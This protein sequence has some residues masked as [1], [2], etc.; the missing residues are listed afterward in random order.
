MS[1]NRI[2]VT[3]LGLVTSLGLDL[4]TCWQNLKD[5]K[6]GARTIT[7]FDTAKNYTK[8]ACLL[9]DDF[10]TALRK[11][12]KRR[13]VRQTTATGQVAFM[14]AKQ[15]VEQYNLDF[16]KMDRSRIGVIMGTG[17][18][19]DL[20]SDLEAEANNQYVI[21]KNM[22]NAVAARIAMEFQLEG[23]AMVVATACAS[24]ADALG[25]AQ[26]LIRAGVID[27]AV[28]GGADA[29]VN[30]FTIQ[31]FNAVMALSERNDDPA[32]A[33]RPFDKNRDGFVFGEGAGLVFL[34][35]E[36][37]AKARGANIICEHLG[38]AST[39]EAADIMRPKEGGAGM[40]ITMEKALQDAGIAP[41][42]VD[43]ISAHGT[44][45]PQND[46]SETM[47]I[48]DV[49]G[50]HAHKLAV[51]SQKSMLG[52]AVGGSGGIEFVVTSKIIEEGFITPTINYETPDEGMDLDYVPNEGRESDV[53]VALSNSFA[54]GGH[55]CTHIL[56]KYQG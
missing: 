28:T 52:H 17:G 5:G 4:D 11:Y 27:A 55:N 18:A 14:A 35:S 48:K 44:S 7:R 41:E 15:M 12:A 33:S 47:A 42:A 36:A 29:V 34:E 3:G 22:A 26:K 16:D 20:G 54:F 10:P 45:T 37:H 8:F 30:P 51:S 13:F 39:C 40:K 25:V 6:S 43:Y 24:A 32:K 49:F 46:R 23:P 38:H 31:G 19:M 2:V 50:D 56:G 9:P 21:I 53:K 1:D